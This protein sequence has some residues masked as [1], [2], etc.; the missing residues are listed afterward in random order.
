MG[1]IAIVWASV[2]SHRKRDRWFDE[3]P[4]VGDAGHRRAERFKNVPRAPPGWDSPR[5]DPA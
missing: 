4:V 5:R 2:T 3:V 1:S